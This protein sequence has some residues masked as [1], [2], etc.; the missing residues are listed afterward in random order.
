MYVCM[1]VYIYI[2]IYI[3]YLV[4]KF[5]K[6]VTNLFINYKIYV[7]L[8]FLLSFTGFSLTDAVVVAQQ[9]EFVAP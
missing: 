7:I 6:K 1:Y 2:Y 4:L 3:K 9:N 5:P 8:Y